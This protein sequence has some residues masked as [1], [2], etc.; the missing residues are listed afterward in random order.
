MEENKIN[1]IPTEN[2]ISLSNGP[3]KE[4]LGLGSEKGP[5]KMANTL[6][7]FRNRGMLIAA[8]IGLIVLIIGVSSLFSIGN[9]SQYQGLI[10][11]IEESTDISTP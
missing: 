6:S 7:L 1:S 2:S 5:S 9:K 4:N 8:I 3:T 10:K 11:Q